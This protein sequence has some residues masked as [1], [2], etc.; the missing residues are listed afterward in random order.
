MSGIT[1][2]SPSETLEGRLASFG[3]VSL[4][5]VW[6]DQWSDTAEAAID[7]C[8]A[9]PDLL[10]VGPDVQLETT[11]NLVR[12]VDRLFPTTTIVVL[13][14][15]EN[16]SFAV[17]LFRLGVRDV[18]DVNTGDESLKESLGGLLGIAKA[19][20]ETATQ[21]SPSVR[22]RVMIV[23]SPKGGSGKTVVAVNLAV[24]MAHHH[25]NK[26]LLLDL[27]TQFGD[28][29]PA[30][31][32]KPD[33][34]LLDALNSPQYKRSALKMF[35][36]PHSSGLSI[37][38]PPEDLAVVDTVDPDSLKATVGALTEEFPYV[39]IDTAAGIDFISL[40]TMEFATDLVFVS[41]TDG[42]SVRAV[43][44]Q[45]DAFDA[46][47]FVKQRRTFVLN[48][49]NSR[50]GLS[51]SEVEAEIGLKTKYRIRSSR[52][53]PISVNHG[54]PIVESGRGSVSQTF[55]EMAEYFAPAISTGVTKRVRGRKEA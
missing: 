7:V 31:G 22:R 19:R 21:G 1:L 45:I 9:D 44:R 48:R 4:R 24:A 13:A 54:T 3:D 6:S 25:P 46:I 32:L 53:V 33:H 12:E 55:Q 27:D 41:T 37:L 35:L 29:A 28:A 26:V 43:R 11:R 8:A 50:V 36:T 39:V 38:S 42:P 2:C 16:M 34:S 17:D 5:R 18:I 14:T 23:L 15:R 47:G 30:L 52:T 10:V 49:A 40:A 20:R 51:P